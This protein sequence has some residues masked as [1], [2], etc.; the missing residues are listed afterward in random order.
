MTS[1]V[2]KLWVIHKSGSGCGRGTVD[3]CHRWDPV[4]DLTLTR[5]FSPFSRW[6]TSSLPSSAFLFFLVRQEELN[7]IS[8]YFRGN[9]FHMCLIHLG[10]QKLENSNVQI[11]FQLFFFSFPFLET[12]S[13]V[14]L[15]TTLTVLLRLTRCLEWGT[16]R[17]GEGFFTFSFAGAIVHHLPGERRGNTRMFWSLLWAKARR[18][19]CSERG[20]CLSPSLP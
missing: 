17:S 19:V 5:L 12:G 1:E 14:W 3:H 20:R 2:E 11:S 15:R 6:C 13:C 8:S 10:L 16:V 9:L 18:K 7:S 4:F